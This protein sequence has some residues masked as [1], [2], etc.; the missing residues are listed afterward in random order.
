M[1][2][3]KSLFTQTISGNPIGVVPYGKNKQNGSHDH[4]YNR[5]AD[6]TQAQKVGDEKRKKP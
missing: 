6:R 3:L 2:F 1:N 4:R 5:G